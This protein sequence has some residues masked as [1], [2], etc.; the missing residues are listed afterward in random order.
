MRVFLP[1]PESISTEPSFALSGEPVTTPEPTAQK[2]GVINLPTAT[3]SED[4][5]V[6]STPGNSSQ[7]ISNEE[8][9]L[10]WEGCLDDEYIEKKLSK[11]IRNLRYMFF[12]VYRRLFSI[13]FAVNHSMCPYSST[14]RQ[15]TK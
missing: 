2:F 11:L 10:Y 1:P 5:V 14:L 4:T 13:T 3:K 7:D 12:S 8:K 9:A 15:L 6:G